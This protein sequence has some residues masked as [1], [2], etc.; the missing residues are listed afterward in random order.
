MFHKI[1]KALENVEQM[2]TMELT[3]KICGKATEQN[4]RKVSRRLTQMFPKHVQRTMKMTERG[5]K[6]YFY[7]LPRP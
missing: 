4:L 7:Y 5:G 2:S 1:L 6:V 3:L